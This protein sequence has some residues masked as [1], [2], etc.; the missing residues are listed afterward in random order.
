MAAVALVFAPQAPLVPAMAAGVFFISSIVYKYQIMFVF[1]TKVESGGRLWNS[2]INRLLFGVIFM[3]LLMVLTTGLQFGFSSFKWVATVPPIV[4]IVIFKI[5]LTRAFLHKFIYYI[6]SDAEIANARVHSGRSDTKGHRLERRFGHPALHAELFTPMVHARM[7]HLLA[8]V[9][10]G[11]LGDAETKMD[12]FGGAVMDAK[13]APGGL[14]IAAVEQNDLE[15]DPALY[16]RDRGEADWDARSVSSGGLTLHDGM[17]TF[18]GQQPAGFNREEYLAH[19]PGGTMG[20][21]QYEMSRYNT[22]D[23]QAPLLAPVNNQSQS[24]LSRTESSWSG[25]DSQT[26]FAPQQHPYPPP[27]VPPG[28]HS[29]SPSQQFVQSPP[30]SR[31]PTVGDAQ[32]FREAQ[33]QRYSGHQGSYSQSSGLGYR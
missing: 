31:R 6:P 16:Q 13:V 5:Y 18:N 7:T 19:G 10:H 24:R 8:E 20:G 14:R 29:Q 17:S 30:Q 4:F 26:N 2:V 33:L 11:R 27:G 32:A 22:R 25:Y 9:Y 21:E 3:Q 1:T 15:Y 12:E 28:Y 23:D